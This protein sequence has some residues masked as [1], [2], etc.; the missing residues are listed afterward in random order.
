MYV[1]WFKL[2]RR[3][4]SRPLPDQNLIPLCFCHFS[5]F[6]KGTKSKN[7]KTLRIKWKNTL[8]HTYNYKYTSPRRPTNGLLLKRNGRF[9]DSTIFFCCFICWGS[10]GEDPSTCFD[11]WED[12][13]V[14]G[15]SNERTSAIVMYLQ[16]FPVTVFVQ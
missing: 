15:W 10:V 1:A 7:K 5:L 2:Y 8:S 12:G 14:R 13:V 11:V 9:D 16:C 6:F 3:Q 4:N